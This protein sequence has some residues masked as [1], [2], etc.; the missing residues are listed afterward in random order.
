MVR[1]H[2]QVTKI[3]LVGDALP[4]KSMWNWNEKDANLT[5]LSEVEA[6][7]EN[8]SKCE[9]ALACTSWMVKELPF[10]RSFCWVIW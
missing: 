6:L 9:L 4:D 2:V 8:V 3:V 7:L 10:G 5:M 1:K